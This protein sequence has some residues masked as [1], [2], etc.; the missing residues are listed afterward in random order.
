MQTV[1]AAYG[2]AGDAVGSTLPGVVKGLDD[3]GR[4]FTDPVTAHEVA[5]LR[6]NPVHVE[7]CTPPKSWT[8]SQIA[9]YI[10]V[11]RSELGAIRT[12][13]VGDYGGIGILT[14]AIAFGEKRTRTD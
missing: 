7:G 11:G 13:K 12:R 2:R 10:K 14:S 8:M 5:T 9:R 3:R 6:D 1:A 4:R